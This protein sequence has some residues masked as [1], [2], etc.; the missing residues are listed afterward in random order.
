M[1]L[2][3]LIAFRNQLVNLDINQAYD[4]TRLDLEQFKHIVDSNHIKIGQYQ[5]QVNHQYNLILNH[6]TQ[7][8]SII[9]DLKKE[10]SRLIEETEK[11]Y[12]VESYRLYEEMIACDSPEYILQRR[13]E[14]STETEK[15]LISRIQFYT[16]WQFPAM[17]IRPGLEK[18]IDHMVSYDPLYL[19]D[20]DQAL[21]EPVVKKFTPEYQQR[22]RTYTII[23]NSDSEMLHNIPNQQFGMCLI[24][25]FFS[26][27]PLEIIKGYLQEIYQ[28]LR[29]GGILILTFNDCDRPAGVDLCERNFAC[30]MTGSLMKSLT[31]TIGYDEIFSWNNNGPITWL[32]LRKPGTLTSL[33]GGQ[34]L[35][36]IVHKSV[37]N[38]K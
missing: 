8:E 38:S 37:A 20:T 35:A 10:I 16:S 14:L 30:Y 18:F 34:T 4:H 17:I 31:K 9:G 12:F 13:P 7:F 19:I 36:K 2:G 15:F 33:R 23:E 32:E 27:K 24:Y 22:L 3:E 21:L 5:E 1:K 28:K 11:P 25:N 29:P 6:I 26:Q